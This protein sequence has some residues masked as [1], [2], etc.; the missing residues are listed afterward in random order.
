[1]DST[2][3]SPGSTKK[4]H[5]APPAASKPRSMDAVFNNFKKS[6]RDKPFFCNVMDG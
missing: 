2:F 4:L 6:L 1:M 5:P 3:T